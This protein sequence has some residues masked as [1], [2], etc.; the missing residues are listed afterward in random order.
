MP[1]VSATLGEL[2][3]IDITFVGGTYSVA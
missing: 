3:Q 1:V 2:S